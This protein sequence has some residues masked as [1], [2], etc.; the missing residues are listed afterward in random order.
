MG[1]G[2]GGGRR[3]EERKGGFAVVVGLGIGSWD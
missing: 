3:R 1:R 2:E